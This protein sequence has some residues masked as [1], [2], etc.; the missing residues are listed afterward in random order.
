[1][2]SRPAP[3]SMAPAHCSLASITTSSGMQ[4]STSSSSIQRVVRTMVR[5]SLCMNQSRNFAI[6]ASTDRPSATALITTM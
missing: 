4:A 1:M 6:V 5:G 3:I 2:I